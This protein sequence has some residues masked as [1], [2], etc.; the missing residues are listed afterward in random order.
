MDVDN[1]GTT[2]GTNIKVSTKS[3]ENSQIFEIIYDNNTRYL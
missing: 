2:A 1:A 3:E